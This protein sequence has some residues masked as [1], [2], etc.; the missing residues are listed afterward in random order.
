MSIE[1]KIKLKA[2][3]RI[4]TIV[5]RYGLTFFWSWLFIFVLIVVPFF[6]MFWLFKHDW[7]G[8]T[9]FIIPVA[10]ALFLLTRTIFVWQRNV[11]IIT[12]HRVVD[13][14][15]RGFFEK[16]ISNVSYDQVE[17]VLGRIKG[18]WGT[19]FRYGNVEIQTGAGKV[20]LVVDK[21]KQPVFVQQEIQE[22][23]DRFMA[24]YVHDYSGDVAGT[25]I[26]QIYELEVEELERVKKVLVKRIKKL[27]IED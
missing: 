22:L 17:D 24:K 5:R 1:K 8:Q 10:L 9:L 21:V 15:Q 23:R 3:E 18:F 25:I 2:N 26:D 12:S 14:D 20:L 16:E 7:W 11:M 4:M 13:I 27:E 6:F 19:I